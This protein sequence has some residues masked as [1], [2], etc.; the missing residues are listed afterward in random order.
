MSGSVVENTT[1]LVTTA[2]IRNIAGPGSGMMTSWSS[3]GVGF[4]FQCA[5]V[6]IAVVG[7]AANGLVLYAMVASRQHT[8]HVLIF[9]QNLLDFVSCL[10]LTNP[11]FLQF[12]L[13]LFY[14]I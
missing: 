11:V 2:V 10:F 8:K 14:A 4:Y 6:G 13:R 5:V 9:N 1:D 7:T 3:R 12:L